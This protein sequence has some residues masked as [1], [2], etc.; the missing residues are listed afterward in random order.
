MSNREAP[1][2]SPS[3]LTPFS[4]H[5]MVVAIE[6]KQ[7]EQVALTAVSWSQAAGG[8]RLYFAY[9]DTQRFTV[10][11]FPDG[12][13]RHSEI[14]PDSIDDSWRLRQE[15]LEQSLTSLLGPS[16]L[17]SGSVRSWR[18]R[19]SLRLRSK[20]RDRWRRLRRGWRCAPPR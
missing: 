18:A 3:R 11:E 2:P 5:P 19:G 1:Q 8:I 17:S 20:T 16:V 10:E 14:D 6:P 9:V 12:T 15:E 7:P 4:N 13:V